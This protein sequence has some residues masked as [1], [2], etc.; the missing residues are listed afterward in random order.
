MINALLIVLFVIAGLIGVWFFWQILLWIFWI[1]I[2]LTI[3]KKK[4]YTQPSAF[5][6][7]AFVLWYRYMMIAGRIKLHVSGYEKVPFGKRFLLVS[8]HCSKFD[9]FIHCAVLKKTQIAYIS[10]PE[11]F[12]IPIGGRFMKRGLYLSL[13][14]GNT[15]QE[16]QVIMKAIEYIKDD[17]VSIGIFPE[18]SRSKDG[19][20]QDFKPGAFKIAEKAKCPVLVCCM[21]GTFDIHKNWP[22]KMTRVDMDILDVIEPSVWESKN[23]IEVSQYA[24]DLIL[25]NLNKNN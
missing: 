15:R 19:K 9:N 14:R 8:N 23:T 10:K 22:W 13:P 18:G 6:N 17:K 5:Y 11:N 20:L 21:K 25:N 12:K 16:F 24:H 7:W 2:N 1:F 4:E 3:N